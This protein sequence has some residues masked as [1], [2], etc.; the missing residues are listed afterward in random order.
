MGKMCKD[1]NEKGQSGLNTWKKYKDQIL[2][3]QKGKN[4]WAVWKI[5]KFPESSFPLF[6]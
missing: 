5:H 6:K 2:R 3:I 1:I 4:T